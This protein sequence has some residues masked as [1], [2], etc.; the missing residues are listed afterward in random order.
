M[1][2]PWTVQGLKGLLSLNLPSIVFLSETR[3]PTLEWL[4]KIGIIPILGILKKKLTKQGP[5]LLVSLILISWAH[6]ETKL[7]RLLHQEETFWRQRA[8]VFWLSDGDLN[9]KFFHRTASNRKK[10]NQLKGLF[11]KEGQWCTTDVDIETIVLQYYS[12][13]FS[14]SLPTNTETVNLL[15]QIISDDMNVILSKQLSVEEIRLALFQM[16]PSKAPGLDGF[17]PC[18]YQH[19]W[20]IVGNNVV[21]AVRSFLESDTKTQQ[22]N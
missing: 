7:N 16:H 12:E 4:F 10:K 8:K 21:G 15:P 18:F 3:Y 22:L 11:D 5:N 14:T 2:N 13:L 6:L 20:N 17:S 1:G 19:F 9:A